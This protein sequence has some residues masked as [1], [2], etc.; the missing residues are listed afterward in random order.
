MEL[1]ASAHLETQDT[2]TPFAF[3]LITAKAAF[4]FHL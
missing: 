4:A 3:L 2:I 1:H